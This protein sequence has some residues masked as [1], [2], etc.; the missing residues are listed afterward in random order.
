MSEERFVFGFLALLLTLLVMAVMRESYK[1]CEEAKLRYLSE[2]N[3]A[4][5]ELA[6]QQERIEQFQ[7]LYLT[8][9][10][11][12]VDMV[13][14]ELGDTSYCLRLSSALNAI[15]DGMPQDTLPELAG[16]EGEEN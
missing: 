5:R 15:D 6:K 2:L 3:D 4:R 10:M 9:S 14:L 16:T 1:Q 13:D 7:E 11:V 12:V 8:A